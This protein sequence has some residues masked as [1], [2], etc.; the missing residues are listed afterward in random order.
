M[1]LRQALTQIGRGARVAVVATGCI[2][3]SALLI[4]CIGFFYDEFPPT[5]LAVE[6]SC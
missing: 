6:C 4:P 2:D 1:W 5:A 3:R